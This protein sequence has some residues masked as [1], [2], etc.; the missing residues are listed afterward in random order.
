MISSSPHKGKHTDLREAIRRTW[1]FCEGLSVH[2]GEYNDAIKSQKNIS[3]KVFFYMGRSRAVGRDASNIAELKKYQDLVI[4]DFIDSYHNMTRKMM[5]GLNW[6]FQKFNP[7]FVLKADDDVY[8]NVPQLINLVNTKYAHIEN[9]YGGHVYYASVIRDETHRH[10]LTRDEYPNDWYPP[11]NKGAQLI[12]SG[13]LLGKLL[14]MSTR[15]KRFQIDDAYLGIL[16]NHIGVL[17]VKVK[18][19]IQNQW[20]TYL[21]RWSSTCDLKAMIGIGDN[22]TPSQMNYLHSVVHRKASWYC[23][24]LDY[25]AYYLL[26]L[27]VF[28]LFILLFM[29]QRYCPWLTIPILVHSFNIFVKRIRK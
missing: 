15:M 12:I 11:Y 7:Q 22:L 25:L 29:R 10:Y 5:F 3:C 17:P 19:F 8:I 24:R 14:T 28:I 13:H 2:K 6:A 21:V 4:G 27:F 18:E 20:L 16:M 9:L 23:V 1:G 26:F